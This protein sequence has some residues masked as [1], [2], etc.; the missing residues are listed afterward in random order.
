MANGSPPAAKDLVPGDV[1]RLR[2]GDIV[3][4]DA[5]LQDGDEVSTVSAFGCNGSKGNAPS[6]ATRFNSIRKAIR[7]GKP[8]RGQHGGGLGLGRLEPAW[9]AVMD[10]RTSVRTRSRGRSTR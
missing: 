2:L 3:P 6:A 4:A 8:H 5:R 1:I 9:L 10:P 7:Q